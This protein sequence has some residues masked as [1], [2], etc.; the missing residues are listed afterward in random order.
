MD[1]FDKTIAVTGLNATDNPGPGVAVIRSLRADPRFTGAII[2]LAYD[3]FDPGLYLPGLI[4]G[5]MLI[6]YPSA[7]RQALLQ[8]LAYAKQRFDID[9]LIPTLDSELPALLDHEDELRALGIDT[10]L[11]TRAQYD[12]RSKARLYELAE[13]HGIPVPRAEVLVESSPL[14]TLHQRFDF[15]VVVKGVFYGASIC[16][17]V[18]EAVHAFHKAAA[19]W[20]VPVIVQEFVS[21][22][23][24]NVCAVGDGEGNTVG[25]VAMKKLM[26]TKAGKGWAGVTINDPDLLDLSERI[27]AAL[28]WRGPCEIEVMRDPSGAFHL[29]EINP[30]F[31]AWCDLSAGAG[32]NLPMAVARWATGEAVEPLPPYEAG[33]AFVRISIDQVVPISA[34]EALSTLGEV[35]T[36]AQPAHRLSFP[37]LEVSP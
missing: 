29:M 27:I 33:M 35:D 23:E 5:A 10:F 36:A 8:R 2:G 21:G 13:Q 16:R 14:Y 22:E 18:D 3:A 34:L 9:V 12:M 24:F 11:P 26:L 6:P 15:P 20:G 31:P 1:L 30:R 19:E 28:R 7:G 37:E 25:A 32:Q 4:D 17:T